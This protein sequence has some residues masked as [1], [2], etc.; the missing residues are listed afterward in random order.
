METQFYDAGADDYVMKPFPCR[1][2]QLKRELFRIISKNNSVLSASRIC[3][4]DGGDDFDDTG[5]TSSLPS[6]SSLNFSTGHEL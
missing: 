6:S 4:Q 3:T 5:A 1:A 2:D